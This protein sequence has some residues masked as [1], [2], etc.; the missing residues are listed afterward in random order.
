MFWDANPRAA[1]EPEFTV[2][3]ARLRPGV[4]IVWG[5]GR[6]N[7]ATVDDLRRA[8][9]RCLETG[10]WAV[11][12]DFTRV[13]ELRAGAIPKLGEMAER[14]RADHV[15]LHFVTNGGA[16]DGLLDRPPSGVLPAIHRS[17]AAAQLAL[18]R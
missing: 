10:P 13:T 17:V 1:D 7:R 3:W 14:A 6:L 12:V 8:V 18:G 9:D 15:G 4:P 5:R 16:L 2:E 11:V